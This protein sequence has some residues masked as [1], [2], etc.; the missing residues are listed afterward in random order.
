MKQ[1]LL[2][3]TKNVH[4][5]F[6]NEIYLQCDGVAMESHFRT[7]DRWNIYGRIGKV[8]NSNLDGTHVSLETI[9]RRH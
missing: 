8:I 1:L 5:T 4:F 3:C 2:K 9:C 6:K 7:S